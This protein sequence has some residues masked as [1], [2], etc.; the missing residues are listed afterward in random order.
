MKKIIEGEKFVFN[1]VKNREEILQ[2]FLRGYP[3]GF[4]VL[5]IRPCF[6]K[7]RNDFS[8][9]RAFW[10]NLNP[11][12]EPESKSSS[13]RLE[14]FWLKRARKKVVPEKTLLH[15]KKIFNLA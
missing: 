5:F 10:K 14:T 1:G 3:L 4:L 6:K 13:K 9:T 7:V 12:S 15:R 8:I 2:K 11:P